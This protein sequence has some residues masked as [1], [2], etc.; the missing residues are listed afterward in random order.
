MPDPVVVQGKEDALQHPEVFH[1]SA[2]KCGGRKTAPL[3][4]FPKGNLVP[5][6]RSRQH[7]MA[8]RRL[9]PGHKPTNRC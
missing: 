6:A 9:H 3:L 8:P 1:R 4:A 7:A 2:R 5:W